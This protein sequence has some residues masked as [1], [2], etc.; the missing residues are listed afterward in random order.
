M[1]IIGQYWA[2]R[3]RRLAIWTGTALVLAG[4]AEKGAHEAMPARAADAALC[5]MQGACGSKLDCEARTVEI[6]GRVDGANI[7]D[8]RANPQFAI[9]KF[10]LQAEA[11]R[12]AIEVWMDQMPA[13][14]RAIVFD[15][16]R[17]AQGSGQRVALRAEGVGVDV[18]ITGSCQR[19]L[20]F[21]LRAAGALSLK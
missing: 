14:E 8:R 15:R 17:T 7:H 5:T 11:G 19:L 2:H 10:I 18:R 21:D 1:I 3:T 6:S 4:C 16:L 9:D 13:T 12:P 20:R